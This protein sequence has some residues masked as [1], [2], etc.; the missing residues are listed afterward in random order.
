MC[1][2]RTCRVKWILY[3]QTSR[4]LAVLLSHTLSI[5]YILAHTGYH[6]PTIRTLLSSQHSIYSTHSNPEHILHCCQESQSAHYRD[7]Q[8]TARITHVVFGRL[9]RP[10]GLP[11]QYPF[12]STGSIVAHSLILILR[13]LSA[14]YTSKWDHPRICSP[15]VSR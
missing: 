6:A 15:W 3:W 14:K 4:S 7:R 5:S 12:N 13:V 11:I 9:R 8:E 1:Y 10:R 2:N